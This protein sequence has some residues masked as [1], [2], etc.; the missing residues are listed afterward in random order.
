MGF[1][2]YKDMEEP[3]LCFIYFNGGDNFE[4]SPS[5]TYEPLADFF[6]LT[7]EERTCPR[8][9]GYSGS[10]WQNRVQWTRQRLINYGYLDGSRRER[11]RLTDK[12]IQRASS[13][14]SKYKSLKQV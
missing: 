12:G 13:V 7:E 14:S 5:D 8:P 3:F 10:Y 9:D 2:E 6:E 11:W 1:P 4:V